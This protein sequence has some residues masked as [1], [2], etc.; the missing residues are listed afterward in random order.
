MVVSDFKRSNSLNFVWVFPALY[1]FKQEIVVPYGCL[2]F[3]R[4]LGSTSLFQLCMCFK[5]NFWFSLVW[6]RFYTVEWL[7]SGFL[8]ASKCCLL[9]SRSSVLALTSQT[10]CLPSSSQI[11]ISA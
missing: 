2:R 9:T 6:F 4:F 8:P 11:L 3:Y 1:V 5:R 7:T 10:Q